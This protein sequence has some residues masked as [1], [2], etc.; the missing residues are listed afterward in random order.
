MKFTN[1]ALAALIIFIVTFPL[2]AQIRDKVVM[3]EPNLYEGTDEV[4]AEISDFFDEQGE[5]ALAKYFEEMD[6]A[7]YSSGFIVKSENGD[8]FLITSSKAV[9]Q[10]ESINII[11]HPN[12]S[13]EYKLANIPVLYLDPNYKIAISLLNENDIP[14][15]AILTFSD[16]AVTQDMRVF[17]AG[18]PDLL[19]KPS[20]QLTDGYVT[21]DSLSLNVVIDESISKVL[22]HSS[23]TDSGSDGGPLL[24]RDAKGSFSVVGINL[25]KSFSRESVNFALPLNAVE[26]VIAQASE[27]SENRDDPEFR[28]KE[29]ENL[30]KILASELK[31]DNPK[32]SDLRRFISYSFL[33]AEGWN[34]FQY[35]LETEENEEYLK[36]WIDDFINY[37]SIETMRS[38]IFYRFIQNIETVR[39]EYLS[40][41]F[42][43]INFSDLQKIG[44]LNEIRTDFLVNGEPFEISWKFEFGTWRISDANLRK[45]FVVAKS[46]IAPPISTAEVVVNTEVDAS[47]GDLE[48]DSEKAQSDDST[49]E[50]VVAEK[51]E[52][53]SDEK[54]EAPEKPD[55]NL[56]FG[57]NVLL[58]GVSHYSAGRLNEGVLYTIAGIGGIGIYFFSEYMHGR[59]LAEYHSLT[60]PDQRQYALEVVQTYETLRIAGFS[61]WAGSIVVSIISEIIQ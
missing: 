13:N 59:A 43:E 22:Q 25:W 4:F 7:V 33:P 31:S 46:Y 41:Y 3:V 5:V 56:H 15:S 11:F 49:T 54:V 8:V 17:S 12:E 61:A 14:E 60:L 30:C 34:S 28:R 10:S 55:G 6:N 52:F 9:N 18:Y 58:P 16:E 2:S 40:I 53:N 1:K 21:N 27:I 29:L 45:N 24:V 51:S 23:Q 42:S 50:I 19:G 36:Q 38:A 39:N 26:N 57:F 37:S 35:V 32:Y 48:D 47:E 44:R 20:W